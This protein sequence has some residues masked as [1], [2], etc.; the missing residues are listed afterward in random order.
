MLA[1]I[2]E[3][4]S[5]EGG[6][7][8]VL[9]K[10]GRACRYNLLMLRKQCPCANCRGGHSVDSVRTTEGITDIR[11]VSWKKVGRYALALTWSDSHDLGIYTYDRLRACCES[12]G[13]YE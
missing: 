8:V 7:L 2:P 4:V 5:Q 1:T 6:E 3:A 13:S 9:W 10:D 12:N 11:L